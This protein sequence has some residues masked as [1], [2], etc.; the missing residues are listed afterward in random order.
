MLPTAAAGA[1]SHGRRLLPGR[2]LML[3]CTAPPST[4]RHLAQPAGLIFDFRQMFG[5]AVISLKNCTVHL[6]LNS[7][8]LKPP[9]K[10]LT[11]PLRLKRC[12]TSEGRYQVF[13]VVIAKYKTDQPLVAFDNAVHVSEKSSNMVKLLKLPPT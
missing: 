4:R 7:A 11:L 13:F 12:R 6:Y 10:V 9:L 8:A 5:Q 1:V 2:S 3:L